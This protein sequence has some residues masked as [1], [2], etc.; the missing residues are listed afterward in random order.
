MELHPNYVL[1]QPHQEQRGWHAHHAEPFYSHTTSSVQAVVHRHLLHQRR[2]RFQR[3][4]LERNSALVA[5]REYLR[6]LASAEAV[7]PSKPRSLST[8]RLFLSA[9]T[10]EQC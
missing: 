8:F 9:P 6:Q 1:K 5:V 4:R 3:Q 10:D 7:A 2:H